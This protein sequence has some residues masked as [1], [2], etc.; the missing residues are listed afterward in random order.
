[1]NFPMT[2]A[3]T[4]GFLIML[5]SG[6]M[7]WTGFGRIKHNVAFGTGNVDELEKRARA[8]GNL[9][10]NAAIFVIALGLL[11]AS[12]MNSMVVMALA[13]TFVFAR[14]SHAV[15]VGVLPTGDRDNPNIPRALGATATGLIGLT[16][17][18]LLI[19][20]I[21]AAMAAM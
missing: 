9:A 3:L 6:L 19:W 16:T 11:E 20:Q 8:H 10:E 5:Q 1:M 13:A 2:A 14:L 17:G 12:G 21:T 18:G 4:G 15:G 7:M